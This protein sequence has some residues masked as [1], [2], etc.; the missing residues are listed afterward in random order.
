MCYAT[1]GTEDAVPP[2]NGT[3]KKLMQSKHGTG[4][5]TMELINRQAA[6]RATW[7]EPS[8][9]DPYNVLTEVR[10]RLYALPTIDDVP[11][12]HGEWI[13]MELGDELVPPIYKC[14]ACESKWLGVGGYIYCPNCG[15]LMDGG[16]QE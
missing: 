11:V 9:T 16:K 12:V 14:S 10:D 7:Q 6:I 1:M 13:N 15:A 4:G 2:V 8:Y 3:M 5:R